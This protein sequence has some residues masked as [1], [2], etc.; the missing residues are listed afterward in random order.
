MVYWVRIR[1]ITDWGI[2][3][4]VVLLQDVVLI[5]TECTEGYAW[6]LLHSSL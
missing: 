4:V 1:S 2:V 6:L 5:T 3:S